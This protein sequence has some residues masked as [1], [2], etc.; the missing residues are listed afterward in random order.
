MTQVAAPAGRTTAPGTPPRVLPV[1]AGEGN[2]HRGD[3]DAFTERVPRIGA[4]LSPTVVI[5]TSGEISEDIRNVFRDGS[6]FYSGAF[7]TRTDVLVPEISSSRG[8][9]IV[10]AERNRATGC[11][12]QQVGSAELTATVPALYHVSGFEYI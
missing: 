8:G 3:V 7:P 10:T 11:G 6:M 5:G 1:T 9:D 12:P 4:G 2:Q